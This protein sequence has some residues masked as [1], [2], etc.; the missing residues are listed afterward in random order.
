M[1]D[2][3]SPSSDSSGTGQRLGSF[4]CWAVVFADIGTSVY[5]TP[6]ILFHQVGIHAAIFVVLTLCVFVLLT[7]KY[8]EVAIRY[9]GGGGVVTVATQAIHPFA[10]LLGGMFIL[11]DYF[12]TAAIS[13]LSGLIY[14]SVVAPGLKPV[15]LPATVAALILLAL[16]NLVGV[17]AK[18]TAV[19]ACIAA[20]SQLAVVGAVLVSQGPAHAL[21]AVSRAFSGPH[22]TP[23]TLL[24]GYAGAF[25]AFS[26]LESIAQL[27]PTMQEPR[28]RVSHLAMG[29][30]VA[31]VALSSPLLT[32]WSTTLVN[33][34][35]SDP[36]QFISLLAGLASGKVLQSEVAVTGAV[37]LVFASNTAIIG[38]YHVFLALS[39]MRFLPRLVEQ[40]N[41][42]RG[43]PHWAILIAM[44]IPLAVLLA[45][46]GNVGLLGDLYAFGLLGAFSMTCVSLDIVRWHERH[47]HPSTGEQGNNGRH[48]HG[49]TQ[50]RIPSRTTFVVGVITTF[51]VTLA[52]TTNLFAK[53]LATLFGGVVT[54]VGL[55]IG[56]TTYARAQRGG[57]PAVFPLVH[58]AGQPVFFL[59]RARRMRPVSVMAILPHDP[60]ESRAVIEAAADAAPA[61]PI[62]FLHRQGASQRARTPEIFEVVSPYLDDRA[63]QEAFGAAERVARAR[64][65]DR[66]YLYVPGSDEP[67]AIADLWNALQ[68]E[69]TIVASADSGLLSK[70]PPTLLQGPED[71]SESIL[72]YRKQRSPS[73]TESR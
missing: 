20:A 18:V 30:V 11:V 68:P 23:L 13:G 61:E 37:L 72:Q 36:N 7:L 19:V 5:Y 67:T 63:A 47:P 29:A 73:M 31:T 55:A 22:L 50:V 71:T 14:L 35:G 58:Q 8:A 52:W 65:L 53:P 39:R 70:I 10:G 12:L 34:K 17:S 64:H 27:A 46:R 9:R 66:R 54:L 57:L 59:S 33:G 69:R 28:R 24:T 26:G 41:S 40:R 44:G 49:D 16:L 6:G 56:L 48:G 38:S 21:S 51:L 1:P 45:V 32:L 3:S 4:L 25:L 43:T 2:R 15:V 42:W 60:D 62:V